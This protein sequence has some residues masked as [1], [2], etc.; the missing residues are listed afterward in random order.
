M[1]KFQHA[2]LFQNDKWK[3]DLIKFDVKKWS[4]PEQRKFPSTA[5][6]PLKK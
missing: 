3:F 1:I 5:T 6:I 2:M 4:I